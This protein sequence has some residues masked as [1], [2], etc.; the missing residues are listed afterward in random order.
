[1]SKARLI[2]I[3]NTP[4]HRVAWERG[5]NWARKA[6]TYKQLRRLTQYFETFEPD[7]FDADPE[8]F[9]A[10]GGFVA[11]RI[12]GSKAATK[13]AV[14]S[15]LK[16]WFGEQPPSNL[17]LFAFMSGAYDA[18]GELTPPPERRRK[19]KNMSPKL[20]RE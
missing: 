17:A 15:W 14:S 2:L 3:A 4:E 8:G 16:K 11:L 1:M 19:R 9:P 13:E 5:F 18:F 20:S 7:S 10:R 12:L 6:A